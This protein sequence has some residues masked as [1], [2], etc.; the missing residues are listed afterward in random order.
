MAQERPTRRERERQK[1]TKL[2]LDKAEELFLE[3]GFAATTMEDIGKAAEFGRATLYYYFPNKEAMYVAALERAMDSFVDGVCRAT[4]KA[5]SSTREIEKL[6][7]AILSLF[8][9]QENVF[10]LYFVTRF[11][12]LPNLDEK[13]TE[14]L[15]TTTKKLDIVFHDIYERGVERGE[16]HPA[17]PMRMGDIFFSQLIGLLLLKS[18]EMLEPPLSSLANTATEFFIANVKAEKG[19]RDIRT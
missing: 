5:R 19:S 9:Q 13:L 6:K 12:V 16:L 17:D 8:Q 10:R 14:R 11:E 7:D 4:G 3:K 15:L 2:I 1:R 18:T